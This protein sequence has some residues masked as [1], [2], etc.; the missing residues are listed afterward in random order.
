MV[1]SAPSPPTGRDRSLLSPA[2]YRR[3]SGKDAEAPTA[4]DCPWYRGNHVCLGGDGLQSRP[5][6]L[7]GAYAGSVGEAIYRGVPT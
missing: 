3:L 2:A 6:L 1:A 5:G 7:D 4:A